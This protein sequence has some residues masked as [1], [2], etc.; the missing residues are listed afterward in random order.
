MRN[1]TVAH[2]GRVFVEEGAIGGSRFTIE[3]P[4]TAQSYPPVPAR[5]AVSSGAASYG[6]EAQ[7]VT[8]R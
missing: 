8:R 7:F 2:G 5:I 6:D 3:I 1:L 4:C